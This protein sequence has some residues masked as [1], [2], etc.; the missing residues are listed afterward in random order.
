MPLSPAD[1]NVTLPLA[2]HAWGT[3]NPNLLFIHGLYDGGFV[4]NA[5]QSYLHP[6]YS[7]IALDLRGHGESPWDKSCHY[8]SRSY[9]ADVVGLM[10]HLD[11]AG[12]TIVGHS[13]GAEIAI[14]TCVARPDRVHQ[15]VLIDGGPATN[16]DTGPMLRA[17]LSKIPRVFSSPAAYLDLLASRHPFADPQVLCQYAMSALTTNEDGTSQMKADSAVVFA[18][19]HASKEQSRFALKRLTHPKL[20]IRG[21]ASSVLTRSLAMSLI[22]VLPGCSYVEIP[23]AGHVVPL[24]NPRT[25]SE[26]IMSFLK[27]A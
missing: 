16:L 11:L 13:L 7:G 3:G 10:D 5:I 6:Q 19:I 21:A 12:V 24:D 15:L 17:Q 26:V 14:Q 25:L 23:K 20:L 18:D 2:H 9:T 22:S 1:T 4:W 8:D 27:V